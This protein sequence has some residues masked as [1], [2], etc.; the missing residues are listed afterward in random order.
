MTANS[1]GDG[2]TREGNIAATIDHVG[3]V[4]ENADALADLYADLL[5]CERVHEETSDGLLFV[6]LDLGN[7][8]IELVE[9]Q[10]DER[11][12]RYLDEHGPDIHHLAVATSDIEVALDRARAYGVDLIDE[13][14]RS[15]AWDHDIAFLHPDST[16][17]VLLEFVEH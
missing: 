8:Y 5:G 13:Q 12:A 15:G 3:I 17:G 14:P 6:F 2:P 10:E 9:P 16:G 11:I 1:G 7:G 4:T